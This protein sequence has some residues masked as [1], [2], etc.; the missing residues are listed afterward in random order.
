MLAC[1]VVIPA[2]KCTVNSDAI[3]PRE[4]NDIEV[5]LIQE[6]SFELRKADR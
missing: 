6:F 4:I 5:R 3:I 2:V 1:S